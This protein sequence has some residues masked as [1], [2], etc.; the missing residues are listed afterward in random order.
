MGNVASVTAAPPTKRGED[1]DCRVTGCAFPQCRTTR[2]A[3][4]VA[5]QTAKTPPAPQ[6]RASVQATQR[7][8]AFD[9]QTPKPQPWGLQ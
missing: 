4:G 5:I 8:I 2:T 6:T 3:C 7:E 1:H 9:G